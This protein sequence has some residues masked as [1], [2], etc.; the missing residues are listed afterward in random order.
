MFAN[1]YNSDREGAGAC[2]RYVGALGDVQGARNAFQGPP[3]ARTT[4]RSQY[5]LFLLFLFVFDVYS[6]PVSS[7]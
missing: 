5:V 6:A 1:G 2:G 4:H 3:A 7:V